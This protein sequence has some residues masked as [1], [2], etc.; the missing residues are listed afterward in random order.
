MAAL[1]AFALSVLSVEQA[2]ERGPWQGRGPTATNNEESATTQTVQRP[3]RST[4]RATSHYNS[5]Q[6]HCTTDDNAPPTYATAIKQKNASRHSEEGRELLPGYSCTVSAEAKVLLNLELIN[7]LHSLG[8][9]E[10][11]EVYIIVRGTMLS[12]H[13]VKDGVCGKHLRTYTLQHAE[14]GLAADTAYTVL[15][16]NTRLAHLIPGPARQKAFKKDPRLFKAVKQHILRIRLETDQLLFAQSTEQDNHNLINAISAGIDIAQP[17][18]ERSASRQCT[19][20]RRRRRARPQNDDVND[21]TLIAEQERLLREMY[22][23]LVP[24]EQTTPAREE[25]EVDVSELREESSRP[26]FTRSSTQTSIE[27]RSGDFPAS[28]CSNF[29]ADG[30]WRPPHTRTQAQCLRYIRRCMPVLLA[31]ATRASDVLIYNGRR[32]KINWRHES[33]DDWELKPP[34]Y[35]S[36]GFNVQRPALDRSTTEQRLSQADSDIITPLEEGLANLD[37][38]KVVSGTP[39]MD[40]T[41]LPRSKGRRAE[42]HNMTAMQ[43]VVYCF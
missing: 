12:I 30:K 19:V 38:T 34:S 29:S 15:S 35:R 9:T 1:S 33:L 17:I 20:P 2:M 42:S 10:W 16:P 37:L 41:T 23:S 4:R 32:V 5:F 7:P 22:P 14:V 13:R 26:A 27:S 43:G 31:D 25:E 28:D 40:K 11:R 18:D 8:E 36:H 21:P 6:T 39:S 3:T 24:I